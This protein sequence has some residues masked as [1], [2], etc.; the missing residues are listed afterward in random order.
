MTNAL[1]LRGKDKKSRG[2]Y[3][4][5]EGM[6]LLSKSIM[7]VD[8]DESFL[9]LA[10][11]FLESEGYEVVTATGGEECLKKLKDTDPDL[12][13]LD[14]M[15]PRMDGWDTFER[16]QAED[17]DQKVVFLSALESEPNLE[18]TGVLDYIVKRRPFTKE[19]FVKR[20]RRVIGKP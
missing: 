15:M 14:M 12:I 16:I 10:A 6:G 9:E 5:N 11:T 18:S 20:V 3:K 13:L 7:V 17:P 4:E 1:F 8:D 2:E 19:K